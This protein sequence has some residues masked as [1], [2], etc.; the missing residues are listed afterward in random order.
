MFNRFLL[1]QESMY[2]TTPHAKTS[3]PM[4]AQMGTTWEQLGNLGAGC[5][6]DN[7]VSQKLGLLCTM[8]H[9][10]PGKD[11]AQ[12]FFSYFTFQFSYLTSQFKYPPGG[13]WMIKAAQ[14]HI[15][16]LTMDRITVCNEKVNLVMARQQI[17]ST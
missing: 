5:E 13:P 17:I 12:R 9:F 7:C 2:L 4:G 10:A 6:D 3:T 11:R 16:I 14:I 1:P 8:C 15:F